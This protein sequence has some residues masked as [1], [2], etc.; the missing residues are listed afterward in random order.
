MD[1]NDSIHTVY[2]KND[3]T[4]IYYN[5][6]YGV[7]ERTRNIGNSISNLLLDEDKHKQ[8]NLMCEY[9]CMFFIFLFFFMFVLLCF[10]HI[11]K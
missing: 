9:F 3:E 4:F 6:D 5:N 1:S 11:N 7:N 2:N 10:L 8:H